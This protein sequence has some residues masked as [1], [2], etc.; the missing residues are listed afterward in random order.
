MPSGQRSNLELQI[1]ITMLIEPPGCKGLWSL[2]RRLW[3]HRVQ[4][5]ASSIRQDLS[6]SCAGKTTARLEPLIAQRQIPVGQ[7]YPAA[8]LHCRATGV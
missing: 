8:L 1:G 4:A 6:T 2:I 3:A 5:S 7:R